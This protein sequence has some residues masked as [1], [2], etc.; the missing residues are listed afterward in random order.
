MNPVG[1][2]NNGVG[3]GTPIQRPNTNAVDGAQTSNMAAT[4][5]SS[6]M[7]V[8]SVNM[9]VSS[10]LQNIGGGLQDNQFL[11]AVIALIILQA[12]LANDG[13][14]QQSAIQDLVNLLGAGQGQG[15]GSQQ[16]LSFQSATNIVQIQQQSAMLATPQAVVGAN[17]VSGDPSN[18]TANQ[19]GELDLR[20]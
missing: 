12:M 6:Q 16:T 10:M 15:R 19:G 5:A 7:S 20:A 3:G 4:S 18:G 2:V 17:D 13:G 11:Q 14:N 8:T 9:Q 1:P